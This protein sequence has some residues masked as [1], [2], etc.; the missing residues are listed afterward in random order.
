MFLVGI[1]FK[2]LAFACRLV[3]DGLFGQVHF[4]FRPGVGKNRIEKFLQKRFAHHYGKHE[5]I[6]FVI[7][8][9]IRK[10]AAYH[11][12]ETI[13]GNGPGCV[14][15]AASRT[16]VLAGYK[17]LST[18]SR[19]IQYERFYFIALL[20]IPPI[21]KQVLAKAFFGSGFQ[22]TRRDYLVGIYILQRKRYASTVDDIEFLFHC[23]FI[24]RSSFFI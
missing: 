18:V 21:A 10:K 2:M 4:H 7:L 15:A 11:H 13:V 9:D 8:M 14:L 20:V 5:I 17:D 22:E 23:F 16:E 24:L 1:D 6:Q 3:G 12:T 19:V